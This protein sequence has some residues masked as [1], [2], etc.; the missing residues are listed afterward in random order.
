VR[1]ECLADGQR[2]DA[3]FFDVTQLFKHAALVRDSFFNAQPFPHV[4]MDDFLSGDVADRLLN[5]YPSP[6]KFN[7]EIHNS[8]I[9]GRHLAPV[10]S[11]ITFTKNG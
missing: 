10:A 3:F 9:P 1:T 2:R 7:S 11:P 4:V 6:N 5:D 8:R